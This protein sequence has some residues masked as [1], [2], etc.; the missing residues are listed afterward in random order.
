MNVACID[1]LSATLRAELNLSELSIAAERCPAN[2]TGDLTVNAFKIAGPARRNPMELAK[3]IVD[4]LAADPD[5]ATVD[6]VKAFVNITLAPAALFR[7]TVGDPVALAA[8][9]A[10]PEAERRKYLVEFSAPN[11]NKPQ[12]LGHVRNNTLGS[13]IAAILARAG[14]DVTKVN[15]VNDRGVHICKSMLAYQRRGDGVTPEAAG[16]KGDHL[17]GDFYVLY[18]KMLKAEIAELKAAKPELAEK[19]DDEL[20]ALTAI[21]QA[22]Q[23]MLV[24]WE[25]GDADVRTL[26]R[27]M[28]DWVLAGFADTYGRM[29]VEFAHTYYESD[30]YTLGRDL[31]DDGL[32]RGVFYKREDGAVEIDLTADKLDKKVVLRSDGTT[33]YITQDL[34]TTL[35]KYQDYQPDA[36]IWVVGDEQKYHF[37]VLFTILQKLGHPWAEHLHHLA[38]GMVNLPDGKMKSR[39]GTVVDADELMD[40][41]ERL[42]AAEIIEKNKGETPDDIALRQRVI[43]IGAMKFMLLKVGAKT[44]MKFDPNAS[45][46]FEGDTGPYVQYACARVA[47]ILREAASR[48]VD[49]DAAVDLGLLGHESEKSLALLAASY[50]TVIQK[51]AADLDTSGLAG[52]LL[53]LAKA[54]HKFYHDCPVVKED[55]PADLRAARLVLCTVTRD[56]LRDGL[57]CL[58]IEVLESM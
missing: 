13:A 2:M 8:R 27:M 36:M 21:G 45:V 29:G 4:L 43:G 35:L 41:L 24:D 48:G 9:V 53:E 40:E 44:T 22:T 32:A 16:K 26:W 25:A 39:E 7:D 18:D 30:T 58:G 55:T 15:L 28:N 23:Q 34:G 6:C 33:V 20:F 5:V 14:H 31:V 49:L 3:H 10:L 56:L 57:A 54:F 47:G 42:A 51:A 38:Y 37:R 52:Y 19:P 50:P 11:T 12:H 46:K 17:V 1:R